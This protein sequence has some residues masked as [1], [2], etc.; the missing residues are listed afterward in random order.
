MCDSLVEHLL[1]LE[2]YLRRQ[3]LAPKEPMLSLVTRSA[4]VQ[5]LA[6]I[7]YFSLAPSFS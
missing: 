6:A 4:R 7:A 3:P 2:P 5:G 1:T